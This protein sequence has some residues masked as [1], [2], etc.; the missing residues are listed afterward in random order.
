MK[1][2]V[3][4]RTGQGKFDEVVWTGGGSE[5]VGPAGFTGSGSVLVTLI[6]TH[7]F[8]I[9]E[10]LCIFVYKWFGFIYIYIYIFFF[11]FQ[12]LNILCSFW[13]TGLIWFPVLITFYIGY[14]CDLI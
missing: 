5:L 4:Y 13:S 12:N 1:K 3:P 11:F 10:K 8:Y 14:W 9:N 2:L 7:S 6:C